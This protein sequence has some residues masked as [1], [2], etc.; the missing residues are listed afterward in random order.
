MHLVWKESQL[1]LCSVGLLHLFEVPQLVS[2]RV[3]GKISMASH[4]SGPK[5]VVRNPDGTYDSLK[6]SEGC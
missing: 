6:E 3:E 2:Q 4:E 1:L 5:M